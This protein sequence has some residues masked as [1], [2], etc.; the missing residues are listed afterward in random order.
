MKTN[1]EIIIDTIKGYAYNRPKQWRYG[2]DI[3]NYAYQIVP[4]ETNQL[5]STEYDCFYDDNLVDKFL[6]QLLYILDKE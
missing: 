4:K 3:F 1:N 5:R 2:Q 6:K